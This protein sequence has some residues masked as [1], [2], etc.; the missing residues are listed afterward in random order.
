MRWSTAVAG[1][2]YPSDLH[3]SQYGSARSFRARSFCQAAVLYGH[4]ATVHLAGDSAQL[5]LNFA[6]LLEER[7]RVAP[8]W[9]KTTNPA[10]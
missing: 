10:G 2:E 7:F 8:V 6:A 1:R 9:A 5:A 4:L 3:A